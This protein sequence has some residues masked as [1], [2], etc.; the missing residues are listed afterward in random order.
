MGR[1]AGDYK[2]LKEDFVSG[3]TGS[4]VTH[5]NLISS[6]ALVRRSLCTVSAH[7]TFPPRHPC[8]SI[9]HYSQEHPRQG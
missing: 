2:Q 1:D 3:A 8:F 7:P 9:I 6:A 4:T 5:V